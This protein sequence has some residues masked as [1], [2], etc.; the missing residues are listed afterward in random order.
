MTVQFGTASKLPVDRY[1]DIRIN[2]AFGLTVGIPDGESVRS[3]CAQSCIYMGPLA[4]WS[5]AWMTIEME[6][7]LF[8]LFSVRSYQEALLHSVKLMQ[9]SIVRPNAASSTERH[10]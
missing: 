1:G 9:A 7:M 8:Y 10:Q 2:N 6:L 4:P 5:Q 3:G